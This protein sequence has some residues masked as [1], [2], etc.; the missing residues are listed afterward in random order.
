VL[1]VVP[2]LRVPD[3][4]MPHAS[5]LAAEA[6]RTASAEL[7]VLLSPLR[8]IVPITLQV[9]TGHVVE[10]ILRATEPRD[11][12]QPLLVLGRR[13]TEDADGALGTVVSRALASL[14]VPMLI[15]HPDE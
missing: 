9:V 11:A 8:K 14:Q 4:W 13:P 7:D 2:G 12:H 3:R 6:A 10:S 15:V 1:H 5:G